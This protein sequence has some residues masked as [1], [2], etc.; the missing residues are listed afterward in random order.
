MPQSRPNILLITSDQHRGDAFGFEGCVVKTPHIDRLAREGTR[1]SACLTPNLVCQP[2]RASIL[3]GLLPLTHGAWDNGVDLAPGIGDKGFA[4]TLGRA[5]YETAFIGKAHLSTYFTYEPTG[6]P[7]DLSSTHRYADDWHG[8]Y[9]GFDYVELMLL[10]H[11]HWLPQEPPGGMHYE[12]WYYRDGLGQWKNE[13]YSKR[14]PPLT[15]AP[16]THHSALPPVWHNSTWVGDRVVD[17][18]K[19]HHDRPFCLWAS[20]P[21]PHHPFDAPEPWGRMY[22]P[23][24]IVLPVHRRLDL[25]RRPWWH[26][27][28]VEGKPKGPESLQKMRSGFTRIPTQ[29]DARLRHIIANY[30]GMISLIDHNVGRILSAL[31]DLGLA[32]DTLVIFTSDHGEW[33]GDHGLMLKGPMFYE[34]LARV[35]LVLRG[36]GVLSGKVVADPVSTIDLFSTFTDYSGLCTQATPHSVSLRPLLGKENAASRSYAR[37]EWCVSEQRCGQ[38]LMLQCVRTRTHKLTL[39]QHSGAGELYDLCNDPFELENRFADAGCRGVRRELEEMIAS[40]PRDMLEPRPRHVG[41]A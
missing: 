37:S 25:E 39:E 14:L 33:L 7:E 19:R 3:T 11:N 21:D 23:D 36:P 27:V 41:S 30:Y 26:R 2:A 12:R 35:A 38:E 20:F 5:G 4:G 29:D 15:D 32:D 16:Q 13:L 22:H 9:Q 40:R 8:P 10:G 1:F 28:A 18:L 17:F 31:H 24:E 6:T 34:G